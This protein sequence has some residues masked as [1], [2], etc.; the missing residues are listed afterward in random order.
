M[1]NEPFAPVIRTQ[2]DL[3][4][5]WRRLMGPGPASGRSLWM[6][7]IQDDV[8]LPQLIE[9]TDADEPDEPLM[10]NFATLLQMLAEDSLDGVRFA[11][12]LSRSGS[13]FLTVSDRRWASALYSATSDAGVRCEVVHLATGASVRPIPPD[14]LEPLATSA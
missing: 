4:G 11:F 1:T 9:M 2:A 10:A 3:E 12:L 14:E 7:L 5:A 8:P 6:M 13:G